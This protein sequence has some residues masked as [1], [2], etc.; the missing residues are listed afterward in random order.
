[1]V[2][3]RIRGDLIWFSIN[4]INSNI[5]KKWPPFVPISFLVSC[6]SLDNSKTFMKSTFTHFKHNFIDFFVNFS[7]RIFLNIYTL[8]KFCLFKASVGHLPLYKLYINVLNNTL[9]IYLWS[10][11]SPN[12]LFVPFLVCFLMLTTWNWMF[13]Q[14]VLISWKEIKANY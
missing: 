1:M 8:N 7:S 14:F 11:F 13:G 9:V 6:K 12:R 5:F 4:A 2:F 10:L 3:E